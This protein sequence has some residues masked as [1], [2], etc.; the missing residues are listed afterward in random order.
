MAIA[1]PDPSSDPD[2]L[3]AHRGAGDAAARASYSAHPRSTSVPRRGP[4]RSH[5]M[6]P[7]PPGGHPNP[8]IRLGARALLVLFVLAAGAA[9]L[10]VALPT[11]VIA[12]GGM[13]ALV[14]AVGALLSLPMLVQT[15]QIDR[16]SAQ[17]QTFDDAG[18]IGLVSAGY[19]ALLFALTLAWG[20]LRGPGWRRLYAVP[21]VVVGI[22]ALAMFALGVALAAPVVL[23]GR[24]PLALATPL[25]VYAV[26][27]AVLVSAWVAEGRPGSRGQVRRYLRHR[28]VRLRDV[29]APPAMPTASASVVTP[30]ADDG[31]VPRVPVLTPTG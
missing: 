2:P 24:L 18:A 28:V 5:P 17:A 8:L 23:A 27:S 21:A 20:A 30:V 25:A 14:R 16:I 1:A 7:I 31:D 12:V 26:L 3:A 11:L 10:A 13:L 15:W 4:S 6:R 9:L 22:P 19:F 29:A